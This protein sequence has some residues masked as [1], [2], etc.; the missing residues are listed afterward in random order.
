ML[1]SSSASLG[2]A[3]VLELNPSTFSVS[4]SQILATSMEGSFSRSSKN[5]SVRVLSRI[6]SGSISQTKWVTGYRTALYLPQHSQDHQLRIGFTSCTMDL[7]AIY[8]QTD[9]SNLS[10]AATA[11]G[12]DTSAGL[13]GQVLNSLHDKSG[14]GVA[15]RA[16][17]VYCCY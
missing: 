9:T 11:G 7:S 1:T 4:H 14:V 5:S 10:E 8:H 16:C 3:L 6:C 13:T 2:S 12:P 15:P 17:Y